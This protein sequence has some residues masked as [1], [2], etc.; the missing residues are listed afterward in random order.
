MGTLIGKGALALWIDILPEA[1]DAADAWYIQEHMPERI[2]VAGFHRAR[3]YVATEG[4]PRYFTLFEAET[5]DALAG[6]GYLSLVH[7]VSA[8]THQV[9]PAFRNV[10]RMTFHISHSSGRGEGGL[11][12]TLRFAPLPGRAATLRTA[13]LQQL[14][15]ALAQNPRVVGVHLLEAAPEVRARMDAVRETGGTDAGADWVLL[16]EATDP[17][18]FAPLR[19]AAA[20]LLTANG[21]AADTIFAIYAFQYSVAAPQGAS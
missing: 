6:E 11:L 18:D 5:S 13:I 8:A 14:A 4:S 12:A 1:Q 3:R 19:Q 16:A 9:R 10:A 7:R 20:G 17:S 15:P 21:A 2:D